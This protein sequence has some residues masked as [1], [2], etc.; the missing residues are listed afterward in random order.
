MHSKALGFLDLARAFFVGSA[1][2]PLPRRT[3]Q[4]GSAPSSLQSGP[5]RMR[6]CLNKV[7]QR[8]LQLDE[9][10]RLEVG[11][12]PVIWVCNQIL[13]SQWTAECYLGGG[14]QELLTGDRLADETCKLWIARRGICTRRRLVRLVGKTFR[15]V[16]TY[17]C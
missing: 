12:V 5:Y 17:G 6:G 13:R 11:L 2:S 4:S 16:P 9:N 14:N 1:P 3:M 7:G 15:N 8:D 10:V